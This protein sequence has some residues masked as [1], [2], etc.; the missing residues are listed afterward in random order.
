MIVCTIHPMTRFSGPEVLISATKTYT[1]VCVQRCCPD[2]YGSKN[3]R[4]FKFVLLHFEERMRNMVRVRN[5]FGGTRIQ[6][7]NKLVEVRNQK[8]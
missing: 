4:Q 2:V 1:F 8:A 6:L 5:T 3:A 7:K